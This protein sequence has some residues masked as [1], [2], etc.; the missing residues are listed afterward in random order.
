[1]KAFGLLAALE[2]EE[3]LQKEHQ[4]QLKRLTSFKLSGKINTLYTLE[5]ENDLNQLPMNAIPI[6]GGSN[7]MINQYKGAIN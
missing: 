4:V 3:A 1:M 7:I 2:I 6:G 5:S